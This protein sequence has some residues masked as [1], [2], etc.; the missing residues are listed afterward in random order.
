MDEIEAK[1]LDIDPV[2]LAKKLK[3]MG[4]KKVFSKLYKRRVFALPG[5]SGQKDAWVRV[6]DEGDRVTMT[7]KRP[8]GSKKGTGGNDLGMEEIEIIVSDFEKAA[9]LLEKVGFKGEIY[10]ENTRERWQL[11]KI[12]I[13]IDT[14]PLVPTFVEIEGKN[15]E[16]VQ[17]IA[18]ELGFD[19]QSRKICAI[20][21]IYSHYDIDI[22]QFSF[23]TFEKQIKISWKNQFC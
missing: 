15:W 8:I 11:G 23:L 3:K 6:R 22:H 13:D 7:Y 5:E 19:W 14:W 21:R 1:F 10:E 18:T 2:D 9:T 17:K 12:T 16:E 4:G 20:G